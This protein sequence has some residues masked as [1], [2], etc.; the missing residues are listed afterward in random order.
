MNLDYTEQMTDEMIAELEEAARAVGI[1]LRELELI[2]QDTKIARRFVASVRQGDQDTFLDAVEWSHLKARLHSRQGR[3]PCS[4][5]VVS[6]RA[7][8]A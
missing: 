5:S 4:S 8:H 1:P 3:A 2:G 7:A 6:R